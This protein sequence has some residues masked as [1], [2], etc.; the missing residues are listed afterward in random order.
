MIPPSI[1]K[2]GDLPKFGVIAPGTRGNHDDGTESHQSIKIRIKA[3]WQKS[4]TTGVPGSADRPDVNEGSHFFDYES[5][6]QGATE[7]A[8]KLKFGSTSGDARDLE[9]TKDDLTAIAKAL[10]SIEGLPTTTPIALVIGNTESWSNGTSG[11]GSYPNLAVAEAA[12]I[13]IYTIAKAATLTL[14]ADAFAAEGLLKNIDL[15]RITENVKGDLGAAGIKAARTTKTE[16]TVTVDDTKLILDLARATLVDHKTGKGLL[17][18][19]GEALFAGIADLTLYVPAINPWN[20]L[21]RT[22]LQALGKSWFQKTKLSIG[23]YPYKPN[24]YLGAI[25]EI[26]DSAFKDATVQLKFPGTNSFIST[27]EL[28]IYDAGLY[29]VTTIGAHAFAGSNFTGYQ[30]G[31]G[32]FFGPNDNTADGTAGVA[33]VGGLLV[34]STDQAGKL[35]SIGES[36]FAGYK[37]FLAGVEQLT[38]VA[39]IGASAFS[40]VTLVGTTETIDGASALPLPFPKLSTVGSEAFKGAKTIAPDKV[41]ATPDN[42]AVVALAA[43][44]LGDE[45]GVSTAGLTLAADAFDGLSVYVPYQAH[46]AWSEAGAPAKDYG[47]TAESGD[48]AGYVKYIDINANVQ[49]SEISFANLVTKKLRLIIAEAALSAGYSDF[50]ISGPSVPGFTTA[51]TTR[52]LDE[53][54][55][56]GIDL[57]GLAWTSG[58]FLVNLYRNA[59]DSLEYKLEVIPTNV[60]GRA[61][62][63]S[64][65]YPGTAANLLTALKAFTSEDVKVLT[66]PTTAAVKEYFP[67]ESVKLKP[68]TFV[69]SYTLPAAPVRPVAPTVYTPA[70]ITGPTFAFS[71]NSIFSAEVPIIIDTIDI[72]TATLDIPNSQFS[73]TTKTYPI[74]NKSITIT[75]LDSLK[76]DAKVY[77]P[78]AEGESA[79]S[80][81]AYFTVTYKDDKV[82]TSLGEY[83]IYLTGH[84]FLG[85]TLTATYAVQTSWS[86]LAKVATDDSYKLGENYTFNGVAQVTNFSSLVKAVSLAAEDYVIIASL[87][88]APAKLTEKN[89]ITG[90]LTAA[91]DYKFFIA[92]SPTGQYTQ[93][94]LSDAVHIGYSEISA[95]TKKDLDDAAVITELGPDTFDVVFPKVFLGDIDT[96]KTVTTGDN[97]GIYVY[98]NETDAKSFAAGVLT[99]DGAF[100]LSLPAGEPTKLEPTDLPKDAHVW[101]FEAED[102]TLD[103]WKTF[104][105]DGTPALDWTSRISFILSDIDAKHFTIT[106]GILSSKDGNEWNGTVTIVYTFLDA[107]KSTTSLKVAVTAFTDTPPPTSVETILAGDAPAT[108]YTLSGVAVK[109]IPTTPGLYLLKSG[110]KVAKVLVK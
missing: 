95:L 20:N 13:N 62:S 9:V 97:P 31:T 42:G 59:N 37:G 29:G 93:Y 15:I 102:G 67:L 68:L 46:T 52:S 26:P 69:E 105:P 32:H 14:G 70:V 28:A 18:I 89:I 17:D 41:K 3:T 23:S 100:K 71:G 50:S 22:P 80:D 81:P 99:A 86:E 7:V 101:S 66:S 57:Q 45:D 24:Q 94:K 2:L 38:E 55:D 75:V 64:I 47:Y 106:D 35:E 78:A 79:S 108:F 110:S 44:K 56:L 104:K 73:F 96:V 90:E 88:E 48:A 5:Y 39:S 72:A 19:T 82:P 61:D 60:E 33:P 4:H 83:T 63:L 98:F 91:G 107:K 34:L 40:G 76:F 54:T 12:P 30:T 103:L 6:V 85:G 21:A 58:I 84:G 11:L 25:T 8:K 49:G 74:T 16:G 87:E 109:G 27:T 51:D 65:P 77:A 92:P 1:P 10:N 43:I 53:L 36:A